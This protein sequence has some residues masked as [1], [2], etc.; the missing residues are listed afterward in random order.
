MDAV[1][2]TGWKHWG[3]ERK[4]INPESNKIS[5]LAKRDKE[6]IAGPAC[7][8]EWQEAFQ[9]RGSDAL[10]ERDSCFVFPGEILYKGTNGKIIAF[11]YSERP[12]LPVLGRVCLLD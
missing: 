2:G 10:E 8:M 6:N 11:L 9:P 5:L 3:E 7:E 12:I 4:L 1:K